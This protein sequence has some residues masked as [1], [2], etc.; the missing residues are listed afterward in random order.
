MD[1]PA[2]REEVDRI[3]AE[4]LALMNTR[5]ELAGKISAAKQD[6]GT[7]QRDAEREQQMLQSARDTE[8]ETLHSEDAARFRELLLGFTRDCVARKRTQPKPKR[9]AIIGLGLIGGS[10][11]WALKLAQPGHK[12]Y[13]VDLEERLEGPKSTKLFHKL[14]D[15]TE[16]AK[17]VKNADVVFVCTPLSR[18]LELLKT[19]ADDVPKEATV[20][21]VVGVKTVLTRAA[22]EIFNFPDA[23]YFV[24][25]HPMAGK[26]KFGFAHA[27]GSLF[28]GR[29][30]I[31]TPSANDPVDK[32]TI[33][34][35]LIESTGANLTIMRADEHDRAMAMVS[36]L[37]Q[38]ASTALMLTAG[39]RAD[40]IAGPALREMTR[41]AGS[42]AGMWNE[43]CRQL[44]PE[45][46]AE[47]QSFKAYLT[48][49][50]MAVHFGEP[51]D[52]WFDRANRL[53]ASLEGVAE[54]SPTA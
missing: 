39:D 38:L 54:P 23:P 42:P 3:D 11:A 1:I 21:D 10:L 24:G 9:I 44:K 29:P 17:A 20:T 47:L 49:L 40:D 32:L 36:H 37:P 51:L 52:K 16:G 31:I 25:G 53:R 5:L 7:P 22:K 2:L 28:V 45:L 26:A 19:L 27:D 18:T 33:L 48:E 35:E 6:A 13:G 30:W 8:H 34:R 43:L 4:I 12:L 41:L 50:E 15:P 46:I 14:Y